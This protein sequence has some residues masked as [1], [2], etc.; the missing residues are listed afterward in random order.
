M[1]YEI[2]A[3]NDL[4]FRSIMNR[5]D[6]IVEKLFKSEVELRRECGI[7]HSTPSIEKNT[8]K[9]EELRLSVQN[10][11]AVAIE[12]Y[13]RFIYIRSLNSCDIFHNRRK[14]AELK[15]I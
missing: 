4:R 12:A 5:G 2:R 6:S 13:I 9:Q 8:L 7:T 3:T 11:L 15:A 14:I 10:K 1:Q